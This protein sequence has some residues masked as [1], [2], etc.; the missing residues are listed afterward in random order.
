MIKDRFR[1][2]ALDIGLERLVV[3]HPSHP[4]L[5][6]SMAGCTPFPSA[7]LPHHVEDQPFRYRPSEQAQGND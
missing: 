2:A 3:T 4:D 6:I 5:T 1:L 7:Q